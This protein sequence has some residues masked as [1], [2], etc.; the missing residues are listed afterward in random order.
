MSHFFSF[1][2]IESNCFSKDVCA[3]GY[4]VAHLNVNEISSFDQASGCV[5]MKDNQTWFVI[6]ESDAERL[7]DRLECGK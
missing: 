3:L 1:N 6:A 2:Y 7:S 4:Y 5:K